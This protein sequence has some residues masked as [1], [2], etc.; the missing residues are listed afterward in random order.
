ML[1]KKSFK[2]SGLETDKDI[3]RAT[4]QFLKTTI[5]KKKRMFF[6]DKLQENSKNSK[7]S[8]KT[9]KSWG[10]N[11][12]KAGQSKVCLKEDDVIQFEPKK[13]ASIFKTF[14]SEL[15]GNLV[16]KLPKP[17]LKFNSEKT[18][19]FY[20]KLKPNI[21]KFELLCITKDITNKLLHCLDVSKA[22]GMDEISSKFL[23]GSAEIL[24]KPVYDIMNLSIKLSTFLDK[25]K[26][27]KLILL[28]ENGLTTDIKNYRPISLLL[29][30]SKLIEKAIHTQT[31][32]T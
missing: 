20:K 9:L 1:V 32:E 11:Y 2:S 23:K 31:Q 6:Q 24:T 7:E 12:K 16:E 4:K 8:W 25:S 22:P 29:L 26:I 13:N 5:Q 18:K 10:L 15:A 19:M 27:T 3:L 17:P 28:F 21:E 14:F 30:L